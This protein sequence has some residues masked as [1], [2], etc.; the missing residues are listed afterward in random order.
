M[1]DHKPVEADPKEIERAHDMWVSFAKL[2]KYAIIATVII[3]AGMAAVF[4]DW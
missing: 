3:L 2:S 4:V 1:A